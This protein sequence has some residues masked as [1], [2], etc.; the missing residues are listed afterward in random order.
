MFTVS[1]VC[2]QCPMYVYSVPCMFTVSHVCLQ[3]PMYDL[4]ENIER[5]RFYQTVTTQGAIRLLV[6]TCT[7]LGKQSEI[8]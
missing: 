3:C 7:S 5:S 6:S 8:L 1:H 4:Q 2:L